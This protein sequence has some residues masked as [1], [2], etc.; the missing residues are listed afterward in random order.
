[1]SIKSYWDDLMDLVIVGSLAYDSLETPAGTSENELGGS[2]SYGGFSAAFHARLD[3][4]PEI[5]IIGVVGEDFLDEHLEW[6]RES[7]LDIQGIEVQPGKTF[8][9]IGSYQGK[10]DQAVTH[11]TQLNV[12]ESFSPVVPE[13]YNSPKVLVCAN[14]HPDLQ[15]SVL[16]QAKARRV[17]IL[18]SM[19]LWINI[20]RKSL[21]EVI[22]R[23]DILILN[24]EEV[25]MLTADDNLI[26]ASQTLLSMKDGGILV[27][28]KG[29]NGVIAFHPDGII[30]IP[31][32]PTINQVDPTGCGDSFAG[33]MAQKLAMGE[34]EIS[35][36]E[37]MES[38]VSATV[39]A[40]FTIESFG[41]DKIR[42]L[43]PHEYYGRLKHYRM[44]TKTS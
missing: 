35:V 14:L 2:G 16:N 12:F 18:D 11:D 13:L 1:M 5:G 10:M 34:G 29:E 9:W 30:S 19:N 26:R 44:I 33:A 21:E 32:Y 3:G 43:Q 27:V 31:S 24:D 20:A 42:N 6:Y 4:K 41:T 38:L 25:R 17:S 7:G 40:S 36:H 28:K 23:V 37:L 22:K 39:T 15:A 8:K